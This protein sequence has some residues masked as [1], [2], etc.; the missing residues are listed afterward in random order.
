[1]K[2]KYLDLIR[3]SK[4][5]WNMN[6]TTISIVIGEYCTVTNELSQG[7]EDLEVGG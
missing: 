6:L 7:L 2:N 4:N 1:M 5:I 3:E